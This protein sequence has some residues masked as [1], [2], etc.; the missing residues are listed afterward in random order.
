MKRLFGLFVIISLLA[1]AVGCSK[2]ESGTGAIEIDGISTFRLNISSEQ[3][4]ATVYYKLQMPK[5][6]EYM[7]S[8]VQIKVSSD[9]GWIT[10]FNTSTSGRLTFDIA[11][12]NGSASRTGVIELSAD[13]L[14]PAIIQVT[15]DARSDSD[16]DNK[17]DDGNDDN[18]GGGDG[19]DDDDDD[20]GDDDNG[21]TTA[22]VYR[23]GWAEL[24]VAYEQRSGNYTIDSKNSTLYYAHHLCPDVD[25]AQNN[26]KARNYT[27]CFSSEHHCPVWVAAP[28]HKK[29]E[30]SANR[31]DAY[32]ADPNIPASIQ[33]Q[34]PSAGNSSYNRGHMLG[35]AERTCT[36][37]TNRQ[38]FYYTNIAPQNTNT[39]NTGSGAWNIL[40]DWVDT[41]VCADTTYVVIGTYFEEHTDKYGNKAAPSKITYGGRSDVSCPTMFYYAILR[42]K[43]GNTGKSVM[44]CTKE[45]L[46]C[47]VFVRNHKCAKGTKVNSKDMMTVEDLEELTGF[48][49]FANVPNA[50]KETYNAS[51]WGL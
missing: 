20:D 9:A 23:T 7:S 15:Q 30:G 31:T 46:M 24:P 50:P 47:A 39:F 17:G 14:H 36:T 42:T 18:Q 12:N 38:V 11:A 45:E 4:S 16:D 48:T 26:G 37:A 32:Q 51:D 28:R 34:Q 3:Q 35:S 8:M 1:V 41:K 21:N 6:E 5:G 2:S 33:Y 27:V 29:Y 25:N 43:K 40:E 19:D 22:S 44:E 10:N 13:G 49:F